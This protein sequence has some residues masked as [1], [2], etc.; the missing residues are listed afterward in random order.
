MYFHN[1]ILHT[2]GDAGGAVAAGE[3]VDREALMK[4][5]ATTR[6]AQRKAQQ[7]EEERKR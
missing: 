1:G 7:E 2:S 6:A 5:A 3:K 4:E